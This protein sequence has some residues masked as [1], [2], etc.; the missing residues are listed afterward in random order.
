MVLPAPAPA[1]HHRPLRRQLAWDSLLV[2]LT[3]L[4]LGLILAS[5]ATG[6]R[7]RTLLA[8][9]AAIVLLLA[10]DAVRRAHRAPHA[11]AFWRSH[12]WEL[13]SL[14]PLLLGPLALLRTLALLRCAELVRL[15]L[16]LTPSHRRIRPHAFLH[17][18]VARGRLVH[19]SVVAAVVTLAVSQAVWHVERGV[20]PQFARYG[21]ALWWALVT[22]AT[23][24]Y[25][26]L[27]PVTWA[28]RSLAVL[29]ILT[30]VGV[31][32]LVTSSLSAALV[33]LDVE[34]AR[35]GELSGELERLARLRAEGQ[36]SEEEFRAAKRRLLGAD[37]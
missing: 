36:L 2:L 29:L 14:V 32:G 16:L 20:N 6:A 33:S 19:V 27:S 10:W 9:D 1:H 8:A 37:D 35:G 17:H 23:V 30:G 5:E 4:D 34:Q 31:I 12:A 28:G 25:G 22:A 15:L 7:P 13:L 21:D 18:V 24:G 3:L 26:D 11:R